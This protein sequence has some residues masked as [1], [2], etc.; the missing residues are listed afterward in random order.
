MT[1]LVMT[2]GECSITWPDADAARGRT[3]RLVLAATDGAHQTMVVTAT[4]GGEVACVSVRV[5][6][7]HLRTMAEMFAHV[8][9]E[10][11]ARSADAARAG[12]ASGTLRVVPPVG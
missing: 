7:S 9:D 4:E 10:L 11:D 5:P 2:D 1:H 12:R 8:A 6:R 3:F